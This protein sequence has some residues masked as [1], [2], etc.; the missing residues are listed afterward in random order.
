MHLSL[1]PHSEHNRFQTERTRSLNFAFAKQGEP[2]ER[3][4]A[5]CLD[6]PAWDECFGCTLGS[7]VTSTCDAPLEHTSADEDGVTLETLNI[8][9]G[10]W[11]VSSESD[12]I[13]ACYNADAC[14]GDVLLENYCAP[15]Y[16][17]PCEKEEV[18]IN[19]SLADSVTYLSQTS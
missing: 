17:G 6:C 11:R 14:V 13:L 5:V 4:Q 2:I 15:G 7:N 18:G 10:Y 9:K 8:T 16:K 3:F 19:L 12:N 1:S